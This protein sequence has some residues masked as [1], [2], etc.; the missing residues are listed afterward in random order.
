[1]ANRLGLTRRKDDPKPVPAVRPIFWWVL[2]GAVLAYFVLTSESEP[3]Q[4]VTEA[5]SKEIPEPNF[6][7]SLPSYAQQYAGIIMQ[8]ANE[9]DLSPY[10]LAAIMSRETDF[11]MS[12]SCSVKGPACTGDNGHGRGLM[13]IDD[14]FHGDWLSENDW[15]DPYTNVK[16]GAQ[17]FKESRRYLAARPRTPE[18]IVPRG[19]KVPAGTYID[20][21]PLE[22]D[23]LLQAALAAYNAGQLNALRAVSAGIN[24]DAVTTGG[25]Y[26]A[27]VLQRMQRFITAAQ[28]AV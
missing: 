17:I 9:E 15:K 20:A 19:T 14:R 22:G 6:V 26:S 28:V 24:V 2:G 11:G 23:F 12:R 4:T 21:R 16:K 10:L 3:E 1:M 27:D 18:V 13:Q 8:V 5:S 25:D 7:A